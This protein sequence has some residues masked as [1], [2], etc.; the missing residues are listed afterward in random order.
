MTTFDPDVPKLQAMRRTLALDVK[1]KRLTPRGACVIL[2][3]YADALIK[4]R[5]TLERRRALG[6]VR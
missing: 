6:L 1:R 4:E 3:Q 5:R 2:G